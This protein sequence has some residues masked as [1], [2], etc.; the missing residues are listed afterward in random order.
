MSDLDDSISECD[1]AFGHLKGL[2]QSIECCDALLDWFRRVGMIDRG[3]SWCH[4][5][6]MS[7]FY[8]VIEFDDGIGPDGFRLMKIGVIATVGFNEGCSCKG[9]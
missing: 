2:P 8:P 4:Y 9:I 3:I 7:L 1:T 6:R 5:D